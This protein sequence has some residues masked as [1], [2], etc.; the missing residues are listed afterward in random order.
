MGRGE[1]TRI[2]RNVTKTLVTETKQES[3]LLMA[4]F[5]KAYNRVKH[6][7]IWSTMQA[8]V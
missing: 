1:E 6:P 8:M 5:M 3:M 7:F 4:Y 2:E